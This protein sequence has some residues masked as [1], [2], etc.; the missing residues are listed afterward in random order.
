MAREIRMDLELSR[1]V[2]FGLSGMFRSVRLSGV[3]I[4][5][6]STRQ[7]SLERRSIM[8]DIL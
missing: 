4:R 6:G 2:V 7:T 3:G 1:W 8:L 5:M